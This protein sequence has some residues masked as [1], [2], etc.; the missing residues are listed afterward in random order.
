[1]KKQRQRDE[2]VQS[3]NVSTLTPVSLVDVSQQSLYASEEGTSG[4]W[5]QQKLEFL[6]WFL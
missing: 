6:L 5:T 1:M 2:I 4:L 3:D